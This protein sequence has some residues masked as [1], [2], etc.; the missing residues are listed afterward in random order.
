M[1]VIYVVELGEQ[2]AE[3]VERG[4][5]PEALAR[6]SMRVDDLLAIADGDDLRAARATLALDPMIVGRV[7]ALTHFELLTRSLAIVERDASAVVTRAERG[8]SEL[9]VD[10]LRARLVRARGRVLALLGR[11]DDARADLATALVHAPLSGD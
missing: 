9:S 4:G 6:L 1:H 2:L 8:G 10:R 3:R 7:P 11:F 5:D